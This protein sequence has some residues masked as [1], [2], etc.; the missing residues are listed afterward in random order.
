MKLIGLKYKFSRF[1]KNP[2]I[3]FLLG[4]TAGAL[5]TIL[6]FIVPFYSLVTTTLSG[7][8]SIIEYSYWRIGF[9]FIALVVFLISYHISRYYYSADKKIAAIGFSTV[10][11]LVLIFTIG[12]FIYMYDYH[13]DFNKQLWDK[14]PVKPYAM[15]ATLSIEKKLTGLSYEEVLTKLGKPFHETKINSEEEI[16]EYVVENNWNLII[17]LKKNKVSE[18]ILRDQYLAV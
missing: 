13:T 8:I 2:V 3:R 12:V 18:T 15:S 4:L 17:V 5:I 7:G 6:I 1:F 10:P 9:M 14:G 16:I 11:L